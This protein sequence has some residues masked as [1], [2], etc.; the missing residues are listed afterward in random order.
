MPNRRENSAARRENL[1][2]I[3]SFYLQLE[4]GKTV[5]PKH[6]VGMRIDKPGADDE[7]FGIDPFRSPE[8]A[9]N[10]VGS[11]YADYLAIGDRNGP[12]L[13]DADIAHRVAALWLAL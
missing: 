5:T 12:V 8:L 2:V 7:A 13:D 11:T 4:L 9:E 3:R 6:D 10:V 1:K